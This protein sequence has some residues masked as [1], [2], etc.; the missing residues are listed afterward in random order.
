[1]NY[2]R[3]VMKLEVKQAMRQTRPHPM[4]VTLL[5][6]VI[7]GAGVWLIS[8]LMTSLFSWLPGGGASMQNLLMGIMM[9][10]GDLE[11]IFI[12]YPPQFFLQIMIQSVVV[13]LVASVLTAAWNGLMNVGYAGYCLDIARGMN[14]QLER[15]FGGFSRAGSVIP[16]YIL[17]AVFTFLWSMLFGLAFGVV[18]AVLSIIMVAAPAISP[19]VLLLMLA[20]YAG[21]IIGILW[22]VLRYAMV[23]YVIIDSQDPLSAMDAIRVSKTIMSGHKGNFF[24]LQLSFIGWY[25]PAIIGIFFFVG[26]FTAGAIASDYDEWGGLMMIFGSTIF[27]GI[28]LLAQAIINL[29]LTP[30]RTGCNA[31]F[32]LYATGGNQPIQPDPYGGWPGPYGGQ[33]GPYGG[34]PGPYRSQPIPYNNTPY[35]YAPPSQ[36]SFGGYT[37][38]QQPPQYGAGTSQWGGAPQAPQAPVYAAPEPPA[39]P[40]APAA[41]EAS[42]H[43]PA[44]SADALYEAPYAEPESPGDDGTPQPPTGPSYPQY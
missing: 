34:Q 42:D 14:P 23:S 2:N 5:F 18:V 39:A 15:I 35:G 40:A 16:A 33:S 8:W 6:T 27:V 10:G 1:M 13:S 37:Q 44:E 28:A 20:A 32:Y 9:N 29:W 4:L 41:P 38:A 19:L 12:Y 30:Y 17:V 21:F 11:D 43:V 24:T 3:A 22:V 25:L 7:V 26:F 36:S 31:R